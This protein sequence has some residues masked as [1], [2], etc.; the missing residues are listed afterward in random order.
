MVHLRDVGGTLI[1]V[2]AVVQNEAAIKRGSEVVLLTYDPVQRRYVVT[3]AQ[4]SLSS[5][6]R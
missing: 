4:P 3:L 6:G 5:A 1:T 2:F